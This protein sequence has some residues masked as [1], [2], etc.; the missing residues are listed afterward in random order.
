MKS[1][2]IYIILLWLLVMTSAVCTLE[3]RCD[4]LEA[5]QAKPT[6]N[7]VHFCTGFGYK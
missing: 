1:P 7:V 2:L 6:T 5:N 4:K 3:K